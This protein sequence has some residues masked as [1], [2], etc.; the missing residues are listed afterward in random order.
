MFFFNFCCF[1]QENLISGIVKDTTGETLFGVSVVEKGTSNGVVTDFDGKYT[2]VLKN[3]S[4]KLE[5]TYIGYEPYEISVLD[6]NQI[7]VSLKAISEQLDEVVVIG[8]GSANKREVLG[9]VGALSSK[10]IQETVPQDAISSLQGRIAGVEIVS[11]NAPGASSQIRIRGLSTLTDGGIGP[12]FVVDGQQMDNID[13]I[14]PSD[15]ESIDVLKDGAS[16]SIYGS[17]SANGVVIITT[18]KG[19]AGFVKV[20]ARTDSFF[21]FLSKK[22]PVSNATEFVLYRKLS[23]QQ[24][25]KDEDIYSLDRVIGN[26]YQ[27]ILTQLGYKN[28]FNVSFSGGSETAKFYFS[29]VL[30]KTKGIILNS[31]AEWINSTLNLD[32]DINKS[33]SFGTKI[34]LSFQKQYGFN[35]GSA[36]RTA[37]Y[38]QVNVP[39]YQSD[40]SYT[41][42]EDTPGQA[43]PIAIIDDSVRD[44]RN[45]SAN[46]FSYVA[47]KFSNGITFKS[48]LA[49]NF[50][51]NKINLFQP[52]TVINVSSQFV[53]GTEGNN[54]RYNI[55]NENYLNFKRTFNKVHSITGLLGAS[56]QNWQIEKATISAIEFN[57]DAVQ[58]FNNVARLNTNRTN[59]VWRAHRLASFYTRVTYDYMK[60]YF[61]AAT[62]RRD[63]SSRFG[64]GR[65]WGDFPSIS[66]GWAISKEPFMA[67]SKSIANFKFRAGYAITGNERIGDFLGLSL[68]RS[69][70]FYSDKSGVAIS[71]LANP[72]LSWEETAQ[73]NYG[74]D[75][76]ILK[77][78]IKFSLDR[79][80]KKTTDLLYNVNLPSESGF[81]QQTRNVGS[82]EN[83]GWDI[84]LNGVVFR[85]NN[86]KWSSDFNISFN[87][88][89]VI[90][91]ANPN[92]FET[93]AYFVQEGQ[94]I[95][96]IYGYKRNG[97]FKYDESNAFTN[98][99]IQLTPEFDN[100]GEFNGYSLNGQPYTDT[101][102]RLKYGGVRLQG[103]DI[104]WEDLPNKEGVRDFSID[105]NDRS[106]IGNGLPKFYGGFTNRFVYKNL[107]LSLLVN[108][109]FGHDIYRE[110]DEYRDKGGNIN[111]TPSPDA[112][113]QAW[114]HPGDDANYPRLTFRQNQN[115]IKNESN[116]VSQGDFIRLQN[117]NLTYNM[118]KEILKKTNMFK[119]L[120]FR[121]VVNN[122]ITFTSYSGYNADLRSRNPLQPGWDNLL[123]YPNK[124]EF[125]LGL[126]AQ[127]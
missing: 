78:R 87:K 58:T 5:F 43:N 44:I 98:D 7:N 83:K 31:G 61:L 74:I 96:N 20:T 79:Y 24:A 10:E 46:N 120:S 57:N 93:G 112:I 67:S 39:I 71:Q 11:N 21:S 22:I 127:F 40:G 3:R 34:R 60:K 122:V 66:G 48:T 81:T 109:K 30:Q 89:K 56:I 85:K 91:L 97:I 51:L 9:A 125:I 73:Q 33:L 108:Y 116:Y 118:P 101:V 63:G 119:S 47:Y 6:K 55:Q 76:E 62:M 95:G 103:G 52:S 28:Q 117:I 82:V 124:V 13:D 65:K 90:K 41:Q 104:I 15:I 75:L 64:S 29:T 54:L 16:A 26:D 36:L 106:I 2:I 100:L 32:F 105:E 38:R 126:S 102:N 84:T 59:T 50:L 68:Y 14:S 110:Y 115:Q 45:Y 23:G 19:K 86:F 69:G 49:V 1:S 18:K 88:N 35:E 37:S 123:G 72:D 121:A 42:L 25:Y 80:I 12:L 77:G 53:N 70:Y 113:N 94:P 8:Y 111:N 114:Q 92:G 17:K 107:S 27:A 99:G 4:N